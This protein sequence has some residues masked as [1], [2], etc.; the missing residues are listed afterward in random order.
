[1]RVALSLVSQTTEWAL[2]KVSSMET[3]AIE[4]EALDNLHAHLFVAYDVNNRRLRD[5]SWTMGAAA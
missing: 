3:I 2:A 1:V 5:S 4:S